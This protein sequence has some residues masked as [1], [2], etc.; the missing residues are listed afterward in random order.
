MKYLLFIALISGLVGTY[1]YYDHK[2]ALTR[3]QLMIASKRNNK[4]KSRATP[5]KNLDIK[6]NFSNPNSKI[7]LTNINTNLYLAPINS[8]PIIRT[9]KIRMEV[10]ILDAAETNSQTWYYV[11]LPIDSNI[12]CRGWLNSTDFSI[13][14]SDSTNIT[15][16]T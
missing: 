4:L 1:F 9:I 16:T 11:N 13:L 3:K 7:G 8:S 14:Y 15:K 5:K 6:I 12:N 2:L 10:Q